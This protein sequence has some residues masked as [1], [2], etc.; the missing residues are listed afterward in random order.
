MPALGAVLSLWSIPVNV[1]ILK[2]VHKLKMLEAAAVMALMMS[3]A[4]GILYLMGMLG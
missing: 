4:M 2:R 1:L 3:V